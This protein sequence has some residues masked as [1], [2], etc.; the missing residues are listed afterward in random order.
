MAPSLLPFA[1]LLYSFLNSWHCSMM[2]GP[3]VSVVSRRNM[4]QIIFFRMIGYVLVGALLGYAGAYLKKSL[5]VEVIKVLS[6]SV[7]F[8]MTLFCI[9]PQ[10]IPQLPKVSIPKVFGTY[11]KSD[12]PSIIRGLFMAA[13]PCHLLTFF[14]GIAATSGSPILGAGLLFGHAVMTTPGLAYSWQLS[15]KLIKVPPH[16]QY[17]LRIILILM[18]ILN[19]LFFAGH[20]FYPGNEVKNHYLF[21]I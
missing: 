6:F 18:V 11:L 7:F 10:V 8:L 16:F 2:C 15:R 12:H 19:L 13:M 1:A 9:L 21:C 4:H 20:L 3:M 17:I 5:E 14:Y